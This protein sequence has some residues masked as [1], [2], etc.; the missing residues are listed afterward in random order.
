MSLSRRFLIVRR[1]EGRLFMIHDSRDHSLF[2]VYFYLSITSIPYKNG[3]TAKTQY[4]IS[5]I[6]N[7]PQ[8]LSDCPKVELGKGMP[9]AYEF[10]IRCSECSFRLFVQFLRCERRTAR[11]PRHTHGPDFPGNT[12]SQCMMWAHIMILWYD[13]SHSREP[14]AG[15]GV[16]PLFIYSGTYVSYCGYVAVCIKD[17]SC[18][19][20][21]YRRGSRHIAHYTTSH[22]STEGCC[23][24]P[25]SR[26]GKPMDYRK[27]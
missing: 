9:Y 1:T 17:L 20:Y 13:T 24:R 19:W 22:L 18:K 16:G 12:Q 26:C 27:K 6:Y 21:Y 3:I 14:G 11:T 23:E 7:I 10:G 2:L 15:S 5:P 25:S 4:Y 8:F